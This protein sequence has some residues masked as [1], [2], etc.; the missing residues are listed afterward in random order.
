LVKQFALTAILC[1]SVSVSADI[2]PPTDIGAQARG[3]SRI[4]VGQV[5]DVQSRFSSNRFGDQ[6]IVSDLI[7]DVLEIMKGSA[8]SRISVALEGG[9]VGDLTLKVSDL[10]ALKAGERAVFFLDGD[11]G[12]PFLPHGRGRGIFKLAQDDRVEGTSVT[13]GDVR[14]AVRSALAQ[15]GR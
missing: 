1:A 10:P 5:L 3:A 7:V 11:A 8:Q 12:T 15:G 6:L 4:V 2:G 14:R 9:T 13:L